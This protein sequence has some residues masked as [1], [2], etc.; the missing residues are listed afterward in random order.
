V[1]TLVTY[2]N[3]QSDEEI[4]S[5]CERAATDPRFNIKAM[6]ELLHVGQETRQYYLRRS[7][8]TI[9]YAIDAARFEVEKHGV[10][11][12]FRK[13]SLDLLNERAED[14]DL[15]KVLKAIRDKFKAAGYGQF[16]R[17]FIDVYA[18]LLDDENKDKLEI[19]WETP[20]KEE[21][22]LTFDTPSPISDS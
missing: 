18:P 8:E 7:N 21:S 10:E 16:S 9:Q 3:S 4:R 20:L 11:D 6:F 14:H 19:G 22:T 17:E 1:R 15:D 12:P 5:V 13:I 2:G